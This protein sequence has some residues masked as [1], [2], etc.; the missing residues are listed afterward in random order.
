MKDLYDILKVNKNSD[1]NEIKKAY[2]KLALKY[3]PDRNPEN[4]E[5][6]EKKFK[7]ISE[8]YEILN[9][10]EKKNIYDHHG[11]EAV[12]EG[13]GNHMHSPH[14]IFENLF[15]GRGRGRPQE[16][17]RDNDIKEVLEIGLVDAYLG[18]KLKHHIEYK[19]QCQTCAGKGVKDESCIKHCNK[20]NGRGVYVRVQQMGP[21]IQQIQMPCDQCGGKGKSIREEDKCKTCSG[22][23][24]TIE[25]EKI[26]IQIPK[27]VKDEDIIKLERMGH[28]DDYGIRG[29]LLYM[30][31]VKNN[32]KF[33]RKD[34]D[35]YLE[36]YDINLYEALAGTTLEINHLDN[37]KRLV[38]ISQVIDG[39]KLY[40]VMDLGMPIKDSQS[41]GDLYIDFNIVYPDYIGDS[42]EIKE[43]LSSLLNQKARSVDI[44]NGTMHNLYVANNDRNECESDDEN[45]TE[46]HPHG[47]RVQCAQQ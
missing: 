18:K 27:G 8:A 36:D 19:K 44:T 28:E 39:S 21:M 47:E 30:I 9:N 2:R 42:P 22:N 31:K 16:E 12:K 25:K 33:T 20:C 24:F 43:K 38:E 32:D 15:G 3:H 26:K 41:Y 23:K 6:A 13:M 10:D 14:D 7:E 17:N 40:K 45:H 4:K 11:Y 46:H 37:S 29:S 1:K 5:V 34:N 35:L